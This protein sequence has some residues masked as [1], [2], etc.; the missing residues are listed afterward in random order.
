MNTPATDADGK[1][2]NTKET[3]HV[4]VLAAGMNACTATV[5]TKLLTRMKRYS[6]HMLTKE[7]HSFSQRKMLH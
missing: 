3:F 7:K 5:T 6:I 1:I 2:K 4:M